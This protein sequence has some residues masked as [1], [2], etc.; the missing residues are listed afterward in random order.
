MNSVSS[1]KF[2]N[3][4][5]YHEP[6]VYGPHSM[7]ELTRKNLI[8][9]FTNSKRME[10]CSIVRLRGTSRIHSGCQEKAPQGHAG[11]PN[12]PLNPSIHFNRL[13]P[14]HPLTLTHVFGSAHHSWTNQPNRTGQTTTTA[15]WYTFHRFSLDCLIFW[16]A[17]FMKWKM[18]FSIF[19]PF[20]SWTELLLLDGV[21]RDR[22]ECGWTEFPVGESV[23][24][25][26][27]RPSAF[28]SNQMRRTSGRV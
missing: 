21:L 6:N 25:F 3:I 4:A 14:R 19:P 10:S 26:T 18:Q 13:F 20:P 7:I 23:E 11:I 2:E 15:A 22:E 9:P 16:Q 24:Q 28:G 8:H 27:L 12:I 17:N 5:S 1:T